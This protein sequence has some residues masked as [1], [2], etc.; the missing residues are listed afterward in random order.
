[1][2]LHSSFHHNNVQIDQVISFCFEGH[3]YS[4]DVA[5]FDLIDPLIS[6][7]KLF[8]LYY[9]LLNRNK[10]KKK[11]ILTMGGAYS[12]HLIAT[13]AV[14]QKEQIPSA[15]L[16]RGEESK[17]LSPTL[18][19]C[20][21][22]GMELVFIS[23]EEYQ[24]NHTIWTNK[25]EQFRDYLFVPAGGDNEAGE[26]GASL[27]P[28]YLSG[29]DSYTMIFCAAGTGTTVRG[30]QRKL[31]PHQ[32][33]WIIPALKI[34]EE[35]QE[36]FFT[37]CLFNDA[38]VQKN[39]HIYFNAAGKGFGKKDESLFSLMNVFYQQTRIPTDFIYTAKTLKGLLDITRNQQNDSKHKYL[40]IHTGG[41]QGNRS[42][43]ENMLIF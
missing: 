35:D 8:K 28:D 37:S 24:K 39:I 10:Y 43:E 4:L 2:V 6:G 13:A 5:R 31:L 20:R 27:M 42:L 36:S 25:Y 32:Q 22:M 40:M 33:L 26:E 23:R 41:I 19:D 11:G 18:Q 34:R 30:I 29:W 15:A 9:Q 17:M 3:T 14:C 16:I 7:N 1:M 21:N 38:K 12:N